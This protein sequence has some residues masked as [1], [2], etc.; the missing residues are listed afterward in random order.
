MAR[1]KKEK[2]LRRTHPV[3]LRFT[4][5]EYERLLFYAEAV[6]LPLAEYNLK[7]V[8]GKPVTVNYEIVPDLPE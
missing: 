4:D 8:P 7:Q 1:P 5:S 6:R 2:E 3:M